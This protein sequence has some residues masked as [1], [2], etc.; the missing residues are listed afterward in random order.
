M[1]SHPLASKFK[2]DE[3]TNPKNLIKER[4]KSKNRIKRTKTKKPPRPTIT[5]AATIEQA[6]SCS[7]KPHQ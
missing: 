2:R 1:A 3:A 4:S 6:R 7:P 5:Q